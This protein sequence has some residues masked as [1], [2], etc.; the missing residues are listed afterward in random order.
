MGVISIDGKRAHIRF[1]VSSIVLPEVRMS[2]SPSL[3]AFRF[4]YGLPLVPD[5]PQTPETL[6]AALAG[7]DD[8]AARFTIPS[9]DWVHERVSD[10]ARNKQAAKSDPVLQARL[11]E[12]DQE[13]EAAGLMAMRATIAR[14][15]DAK[16]SFRERLV[17]FWAD[18]FT[19]GAGGRG[20]RR[21]DHPL[22]LCGRRHSPACCR[23]LC[24][25]AF[26]GGASPRDVALS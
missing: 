21:R 15:V 17:A 4:G 3:V 20:A 1:R 5:A 22:C 24:R 10:I 7:P 16:D 6:L 23:P 14:A 2:P 8:M 25:Y 12:V 26:G 11:D 18:H 9:Y 13:L 19:V